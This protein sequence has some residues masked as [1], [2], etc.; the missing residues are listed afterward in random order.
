MTAV[1]VARRSGSAGSRS[2]S[3]SRAGYGGYGRDVRVR[4]PRRGQVAA[5]H[6]HESFEE[7]IYGLAGVLTWTV[8]GAQET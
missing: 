8:E 4:H 5:A 3:S 7:T 1:R 6:S 2:G